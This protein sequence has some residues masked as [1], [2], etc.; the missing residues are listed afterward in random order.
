MVGAKSTLRQLIYPDIQLTSP[1]SCYRAVV[2]GALLESDPELAPLLDAGNFWRDLTEL[3]LEF[4]SRTK[5]FTLTNAA[6]QGPLVRR[7]IGTKRETSSS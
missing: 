7:A 1:F 5:L 3:L 6:I 2:D 4:H